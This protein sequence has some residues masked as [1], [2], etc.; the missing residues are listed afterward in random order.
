M[1]GTYNL[2][3]STANGCTSERTIEVSQTADLPD[4]S[5]V[6]DG[7][8]SCNNTAFE[9]NGN[10]DTDGVTFEWIGPNSFTS[11]IAN[12]GMVTDTG[13]YILTV[14]APNGCSI[15]NE[16]RIMADTL[17][18]TLTLDIPEVLNCNNMTT[19][20]MGAPDDAG[21][22]FE[23]SGPNGQS[24]TEAEP[25]V[26][27]PGIYNLTV[28]G[29]NGCT[30]LFAVEV[31]IDDVEPALSISIDPNDILTCNN[32]DFSLINTSVY[33]KAHSLHF[34]GY[35]VYTFILLICKYVS[36]PPISFSS[37]YPKS[38]SL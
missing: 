24:F 9:L 35:M 32:T 26:E 18:P 14:T 11:G 10:S 15:M 7:S 13:T 3:A 31:D 5:V 20:L 12:P 37:K 33:Y 2:I 36:F 29:E 16:V 6:A 17:R 38:T 28:I 1:G 27:G 4:I 30:N 8:I 25:T 22:T 21:F 23:W 34:F 19:T